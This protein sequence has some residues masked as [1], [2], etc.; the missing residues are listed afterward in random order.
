MKQYRKKPVTIEAVQFDGLNPAE[1]KDFVGE[2]CEVEIYDNE[3]TPPVARVIIHTL[4]GDMEV[5]KGDYVIK[6]VKGEFYPCKPDIFEQTYESTET[7]TE[8]EEAARSLLEALSKTPYNNKPIT[9]AQ[10]I[11]KQLL[12]FLS[13]PSDYNPDAINE[14]ETPKELEE[15]ANTYA[16]KHGFRVPF[17]GSENYYDEADV[18]ASKEG[19]IAGA[20][21]QKGQ[22]NYDTIFYKGMQYYR[23]Q[24]MEEAV[25]GEVVSDLK[26][27]NHV[28]SMSK[29]PSWLYFGQKVKLIIVKEP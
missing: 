12:I 2:H 15:M 21:W 11:V 28:R 7:L 24:M 22:D 27:V 16:E 17:D 29:I 19:F 1:I 3:V 20:K 25:D 14:E 23:K 26:N 8:L 13:N 9:D 10:I 5:S 4:E 6:G 18:K